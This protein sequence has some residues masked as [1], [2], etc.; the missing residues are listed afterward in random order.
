MRKS[1]ILIL[2]VTILTGAILFSGCSTIGLEKVVTQEK[3][4]ADFMSVGVR[5]PFAVEIIQSDS[6]STTITVDRR[7]LRCLVVSKEG[8][9]LKMSLKANTPL[10]PTPLR[11]MI[12]MPSLYE[13]RLNEAAKVTVKGFESSSDFAVYLSGASSLSGYVE[14][15][16]TEF[17]LS[18]A[19]RVVLEGSASD[20]NLNA[21][22]TSEVDLRDFIIHNAIVTISEA[23]W[24]NMGE[25]ERLDGDLSGNSRLLYTGDPVTGD[26][27]ISQDSV[28]EKVRPG[29]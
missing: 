26:I 22:G 20:I 21:S 9:T 24:V 1:A 28:M 19:S 10:C 11:A 14:A 17:E 23:S 12:T 16:D 25:V 7:M 13:L 6:Y 29:G 8:T 2:L 4:L 5:G 27:A 18:E 3:D 15:G